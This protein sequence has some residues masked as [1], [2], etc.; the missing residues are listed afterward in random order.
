MGGDAKIAFNFENAYMHSSVLSNLFFFFNMEK[1]RN[2]SHMQR[3][4]NERG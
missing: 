2:P 4:E 1:S 3:K